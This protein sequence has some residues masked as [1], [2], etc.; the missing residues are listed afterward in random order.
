MT[1]TLKKTIACFLGWQTCFSWHFGLLSIHNPLW[2]HNPP[3]SAAVELGDAEFAGTCPEEDTT[4][5][6]E[7]D[8]ECTGRSPRS[9]RAQLCLHL[10]QQ[11]RTFQAQLCAPSGSGCLL[12]N[13][14]AHRRSYQVLHAPWMLPRLGGLIW[15]G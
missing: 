7:L 3:T 14:K 10:D 11:K 12:V 8:L 1:S 13:T 4:T 2:T 15:G 9:R 5:S 6:P